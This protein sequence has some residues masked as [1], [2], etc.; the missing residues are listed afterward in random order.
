MYKVIIQIPNGMGQTKIIAE[1]ILTSSSNRTPAEIVIT[2]NK[3]WKEGG[4]GSEIIQSFEDCS[5]GGEMC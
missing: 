1:I 2:D 4:S 5:G 3:S